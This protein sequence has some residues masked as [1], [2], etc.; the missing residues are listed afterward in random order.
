MDAQSKQILD[1]SG[2]PERARQDYQEFAQSYLREKGEEF[3]L[4]PIN[5]KRLL[6]LF[7]NSHFLSRFLIQNPL[8]ADSVVHSPC[9]ETDK[10]LEDF[11]ED[12][13]FLAEKASTLPLAQIGQ[14][15][16]FYKY[17]EL[18]RLTVKD[19]SQAASTE[20]LL[21]EISE[22]A[23]AIVRTALRL[24]RHELQKECGFPLLRKEGKSQECAFAVIAQGKLGGH[25][26]N[27]SSD[28]DL[29]YLY[30]TDEASE[31][32]PLSN[33]EYFVKLSERLS[34]FLSQ[35]TPQGFLYRVDLNLRPEG[36][37]GPLANSLAALEKYYEVFGQDWERQALIR[38]CPVAGDSRLVEN[39]LKTI[40]P[41]VWRKSFDLQS[42]ENFKEM[43]R[44]VHDSV[45]KS[46]SG[47]FHVK[48]DE[49]GI[50][51]VEF[52]AQMLQMLYGG[53]NPTLRS[54]STLD[55]LAQLERL[56]IIEHRDASQLKDAYLFLRR[57]ENRLQM[58]EES[59][60]HLIPAQS[61]QQQALARRMG[62][63]EEDPEEAREHFWDD[64]LRYT[65]MVKEMFQGLF[66]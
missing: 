27:Y 29:Q 26:L 17:R 40:E 35:K 47:G 3:D 21:K 31:G 55:A 4:D 18:L 66:G 56:Q 45:R 48:L 65:T 46:Y 33:H 34:Q 13:A 9:I 62:Y 22:L 52:F 38:V 20:T 39:F 59:Q 42:I 58:V 50:R 53:K 51:E 30:E 7:G 28:I 37:S 1:W 41:F 24:V 19:L 8:L 44:K 5:A 14:K 12:L 63:Y 49:G 6:T 61:L 32:S 54:L 10:Q 15:L 23:I 2:E 36:A 43:K 57:I 64:L 11:C 16:R 60:T 25:E